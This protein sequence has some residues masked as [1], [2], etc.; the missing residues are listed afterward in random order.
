MI[1]TGEVDIFSK[2]CLQLTF[3][4]LRHR[5]PEL[6]LT[7][8]NIS[9]GEPTPTEFD[10]EVDGPSHYF[11]VGLDTAQVSA[12]IADLMSFTQPEAVD[13]QNPSVNIMARSLMQDWLLLAQQVAPGMSVERDFMLPSLPLRE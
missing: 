13:I 5:S 2:G 3:E 4:L 7:V 12:I 6:A 10:D 1:A 8:R 9:L 11:R